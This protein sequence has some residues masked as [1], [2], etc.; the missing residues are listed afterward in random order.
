MKTTIIE[1]AKVLEAGSQ[2][3]SAHTTVLNVKTGMETIRKSLASDVLNRDNNKQTIDKIIS[4]L[5]S[6]AAR[7]K[8]IRTSVD[9]MAN[10]YYSTDV[11]VQKSDDAI[12][13]TVQRL[14]S[15][16]NASAFRNG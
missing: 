10:S 9:N 5:D 2:A 14:T 6:A 4:R 7:I 3:G 16:S 15:G 11:S 1:V 13:S 12:G 8:S